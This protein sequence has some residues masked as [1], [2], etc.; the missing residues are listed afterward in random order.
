MAGILTAEDV[1]RRTAAE[2]GH[3]AERGGAS[4]RLEPA[5]EIMRQYEEQFRR[6]PQRQR[7]PGRR[8]PLP[9]LIGQWSVGFC[10]APNICNV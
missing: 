5:A 1:V 10:F 8:K 3:V 7:R 9:A 6:A 4:T 2:G